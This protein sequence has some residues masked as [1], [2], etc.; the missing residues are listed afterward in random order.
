MFGGEGTEELINER[1]SRTRKHQAERQS[2]Y[3][4]NTPGATEM[5]W[6]AKLHL[7]RSEAQGKKDEDKKKKKER[8]TA[9]EFAGNGLQIYK[10]L[11]THGKGGR[12]KLRR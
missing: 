3:V 4:E 2:A 5:Q 11:K 9:A 7:L 8:R 10:R 6:G 1:A 12:Q